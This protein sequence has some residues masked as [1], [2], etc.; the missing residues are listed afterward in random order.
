MKHTSHLLV[1]GL[2]VSVNCSLETGK[3]LGDTFSAS[4]RGPG[5]VCGAC[6]FACHMS[7][8]VMPHPD[9]L[10]S[11]VRC[12]KALLLC[13]SWLSA[14]SCPGLGVCNTAMLQYKHLL[15]F[16]RFKLIAPFA[17]GLSHPFRNWRIRSAD[18]RNVADNS[19]L[20][21]TYM[22]SRGQLFLLSHI[23]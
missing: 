14:D 2:R 5:F 22:W 18:L 10:Q 16:W 3:I 1:H 4:R 20:C 13:T 17:V 9:C 6:K 7:C 8:I 21:R 15:H 19:C 23:L 11:L 12:E